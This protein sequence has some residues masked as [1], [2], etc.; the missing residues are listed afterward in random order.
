MQPVLIVKPDDRK[1]DAAD[2]KGQVWLFAPTDQAEDKDG[3]PI[4]DSDW[5]KNCI[6]EP[7]SH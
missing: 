5:Q 7:V 1:R 4:A 6:V 3:Y 2:D